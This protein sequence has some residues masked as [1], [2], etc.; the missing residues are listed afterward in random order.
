MNENLRRI[1]QT[2]AGGR[3]E[4]CH[5]APHHGSYNNAAHSWGVA[6]LLYVLWPDDFPRL[7]LHCLSHDVPEA[8]VGDVPAPT[9]RYVPGL[10]EQLG[11]IEGR[12]SESLG[13]PKEHDLPLE[14][15]AK[16]KACDRLELYIW[17]HE[18]KL[19]GNQFVNEFITELDRFFTEVP[20]PAEA[21]AL[22]EEIRKGELLPRQSGVIRELADGKI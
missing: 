18:Q 21:A 17:C 10:R 13:L 2:R 9:M 20:L 8:W 4:R 6:M 5:G 7:A 15:H 3:V 11:H 1:V 14:D 22:V 19:L 12:I 16:L